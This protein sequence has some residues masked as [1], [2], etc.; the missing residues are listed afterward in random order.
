[1]NYE[2]RLSEQAENDLRAI[3]SYIA[4]ELRSLDNASGQLDRLEEKIYKLD[5]FPMRYQNYQ[6][7]PWFSRGT[8]FFSVDHYTIFYIPDEKKQTVEILRVLYAGSDMDRT[9]AETAEEYAR[10]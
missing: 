7:E 6:V 3:F 4:F 5:Q 8:R 1:M 9:M 2:V 10:K